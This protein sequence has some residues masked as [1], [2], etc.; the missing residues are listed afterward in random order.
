MYAGRDSGLVTLIPEQAF[1]TQQV[2]LLE[3]RAAKEPAEAEKRNNFS[4][5]RRQNI[6][7]QGSIGGG[8]ERMVGV[9]SVNLGGIEVD[10]EDVADKLRRLKV[11]SLCLWRAN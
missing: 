3:A 8:I 7:T 9:T 11:F 1:L 6:P 10:V 4:T 2:P 5:P